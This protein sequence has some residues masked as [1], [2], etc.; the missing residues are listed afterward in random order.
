[1]GTLAPIYTAISIAATAAGKGM[2]AYAAGQLAALGPALLVVGA[3]AAVVA[4]FVLL[5]RNSE[6]FRDFWIGLWDGIKNAASG[7]VDWIQGAFDRLRGAWDSITSAFTGGE[8]YSSGLRGLVPEELI[9]PILNRIGQIGGAQED[10][11]L[12][13]G[14][15]PGCVSMHTTL[16]CL[17]R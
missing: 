7:A 12:V 13:H 17:K 16:P 5:W 8:Q 4:A 14:A 2:F 6:S 9:G 1:M 3:I 15:A 11:V 10:R